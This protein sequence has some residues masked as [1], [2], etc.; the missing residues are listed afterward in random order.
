MQ[1]STLKR[2]GWLAAVLLIMLVSCKKSTDA[3]TPANQEC[4]I[5]SE[6][7]VSSDGDK[8]TTTYTYNG[9]G[10]LTSSVTAYTITGS[11]TGGSVTSTYV[12]DAAGNITSATTRDGGSSSATT[13]E[14]TGGRLTKETATGSSPSTAT[15]SYDGSGQVATYSQS[16]SSSSQSYTFTNGTLT[17]GQVTI[18][19]QSAVVGITNGRITSLPYS[20]S[21]RL[22]Y[23]YDA[24]NYVTRIDAL[25]GAGVVQ[26]Y[27]LNEYGTTPYKR[28]NVPP[29]ITPII[30]LTGN[31]TL[32]LSRQS[33]Y[34]SDGTLYSDSRLR[35]QV[36][37]KGFLTSAIIDE[38]SS[39]SGKVT[40]T[41]TYT[42]SNCQ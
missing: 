35:Y 22:R 16:S 33:L 31:S 15:Y 25:D 20:S 4:Q 38:S 28:A 3:V 13:Y 9:N 17:A 40:E 1:T 19:S 32:P 10:Q 21:I 6:T 36:N 37:G 39:A 29:V 26:F 41:Y 30:N 11:S 2:T 23:T 8:S 27:L 42:Y 24:S 14:Y 12:Y 18:N 34:I 7:Y 5:Q